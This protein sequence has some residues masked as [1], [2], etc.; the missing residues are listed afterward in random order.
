M[1]AAQL[2]KRARDATTRIEQI[3]RDIVVRGKD[4]TGKDK[5]SAEKAGELPFLQGQL[6]VANARKAGAGGGG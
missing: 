2:R 1:K 6:A 4:Q 5:D 3:E